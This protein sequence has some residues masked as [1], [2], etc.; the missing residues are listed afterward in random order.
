MN[1]EQLRKMVRES[2]RTRFMYEAD[3][4]EPNEEDTKKSEEPAKSEEPKPTDDYAKL[5]SPSTTK[6]P[7]RTGPV[8]DPY[9][10]PPPLGDKWGRSQKHNPNKIFPDK[11]GQF[12]QPVPSPEV[13]DTSHP[14]GHGTFQGYQPDKVHPDV[15]QE[16]D[17]PVVPDELSRTKGQKDAD[18]LIKKLGNR[19]AAL[20]RVEANLKP[21][22][23]RYMLLA[24]HN[25]NSSPQRM[26]ELEKLG[27]TIVRLKYARDHLRQGPPMQESYSVKHAF[28]GYRRTLLSSLI[29]TATLIDESEASDQAKQLGL[30]YAGFGRYMDPEGNYVADVV[31]GQLVKRETPGQWEDPNP[32]IDPET[33]KVMKKIFDSNG[34]WTPPI[35]NTGSKKII[36]GWNKTKQDIAF[37]ANAEE[38]VQKLLAMVGDPK[39]LLW[40]LLKKFKTETPNG[41]QRILQ[42]IGC[43]KEM[44]VLESEDV[45]Q[46]NNP[47][48]APAPTERPDGTPM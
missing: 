27:H 48:A 3:E 41:K 37:D 1:M 10:S 6:L 22:V 46:A 45:A 40:W 26:A 20:R 44:G 39:R 17:L 12:Q 23:E 16:P 13:K 11:A 32:V 18:G 19:E 14:G 34:E 30:H 28:G 4:P 33:D 25:S 43:L 9:D 47:Q 29:E 15:Q 35:Q 2:L 21:F 7:P 38:T 42:Y 5:K 8:Q 24:K 36:P 31:N